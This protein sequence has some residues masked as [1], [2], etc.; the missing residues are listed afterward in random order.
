V[1]KDTDAAWVA[2]MEQAPLQWIVDD[3]GQ[4]HPVQAGLRWARW[5]REEKLPGGLCVVGRDVWADGSYLSTVFLGVDMGFGMGP[6]PGVFWET[7]FFPAGDGERP[8]R[9]YYSQ[10]EALAGH[11]ALKREV[12]DDYPAMGEVVSSERWIPPEHRLPS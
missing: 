3:D 4:P 11:E 10:R 9:R 6:G 8:Q 7:M 1:D 5:M 2:A 12:I